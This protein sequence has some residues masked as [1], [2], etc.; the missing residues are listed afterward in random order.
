MEQAADG[1][2]HGTGQGQQQCPGARREAAGRSQ[3]NEH[4]EKNERD[5]QEGTKKTTTWLHTSS[6]ARIA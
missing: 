5:Q 4:Q 6:F 3:E 2:E 1:E